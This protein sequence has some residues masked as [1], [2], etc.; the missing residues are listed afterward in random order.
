MYAYSV[1]VGAL[2]AIYVTN[3]TNETWGVMGWVF[4]LFLNAVTLFF[5]AIVIYAWLT[6][7]PTDVDVI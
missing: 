7:Y 6:P 4:D 3:S 1:L 5:V 2:F